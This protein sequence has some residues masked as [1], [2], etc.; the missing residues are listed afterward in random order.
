LRTAAIMTVMM[1]VVVT[2]SFLQRAGLVQMAVHKR[3][4]GIARDWQ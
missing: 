4:R 2:G 3:R 1:G